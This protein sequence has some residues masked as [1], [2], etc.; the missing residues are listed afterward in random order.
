[1]NIESL[2]NE[3]L[4]DLFDYF[5][6]I[7][8]FHT[9]YGLNTCFNLL[10]C[11]QYPLHCFTF[12]SMKK[13][14]FD[15]L[16]QQHIPRLT[17]R[18]YG[19][20]FAE[21][22]Q[23]PGQM[24]L[25]FTYIPSFEQ[26][27]GLRSLSLQNITSSETLIKVIQELP[28]LLN[29]MHLTINFYYIQEH[30]IDFQWVN[31]TIWSLPKLRICSLTN[32]TIV[33]G[34]F[35]I[36][37]KISSSLQSV[38]MTSFKL[39]INQIDQLMKNTPHLKHLSI[40]TK[41]SSDMNDDYNSSSLSTLI[42]LDMFVS[43]IFDLSKMVLFLKNLSNLR[44]LNIRFRNNM[45]NGY[46]WE[47]IIRNYLFKLKI[48]ELDMSDD[49]STNQNIEDYM[50][51]LL[52]SFQ[53]SFW[54]NEHQWFVHC[55]IV[56][57]TIHL[58]T[59]SKCYYYYPDQ[60]LPRIWKSTNPKDTQQDLYRSITMINEKYFEQPMPSDICL[61]KIDY[62]TIKFPLHNQFWSAISNFNRLY[63]INVLS[64]NDTYQSELQN[65]FDRAP[66]LR[67]LCIN[68]DDSLPL[69]ASFF[70]CINPSIH[71]LSFFKMNHCLNEEECSL[72]CDSPL[73]MQCET[74]SFNVTNRH[75]I[76]I[77]VKNMIN[78]QALH[79]YCQEISE[80]NRVEVIK[81]LKDS[82]PS[83]CFVTRDP[84]SAIGVRIWM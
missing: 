57:E 53:S 20:S 68:Q 1:M 18:V 62:I 29:L 24:D 27:S 3:I 67:S 37:A 42:N 77:L 32:F 41:I 13:S 73:G 22:A 39:H 69:Q 47:Q 6:G 55:Y 79:I 30:L 44:H 71:S 51:Q 36:P 83:T 46:E 60:K 59:S 43:H 61:S 64:Y 12:S 40:Y 35:C 66:K 19:L 11:K 21:Y 17:N 4:L 7:D 54:I 45:I 84:Y 14:Q 31:D 28:Y 33:S 52:D 38:K 49:I 16:C 9:F 65:L 72:F 58:S 56:D 15:E 23:T 5:D 78:L 2:A 34:K 10:I 75:C 8:L 70:K 48:F 81:W 63:G 76:T 74:C 80:E 82:L 25:F 50:N 26:F